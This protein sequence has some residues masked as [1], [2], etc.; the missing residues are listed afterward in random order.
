MPVES[1]D[2]GG[3][4]DGRVA[5]TA[6]CERKRRQ[7][8]T[9]NVNRTNS[10]RLGSRPGQQVQRPLLGNQDRVEKSA[11]GKE[12]RSGKDDGSTTSP[13]KSTQRIKLVKDILT[14]GTWSVQTL[15]ATGKLE[16]LRNEMKRFRHDIIGISEVRWTGK[17]SNK[18]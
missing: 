16:L 13:P 4:L 14:A 5:D 11:T 12:T 17:G 7:K 2:K 3:A 9:M 6:A 18:I 1:P 15:W 10:Y 8:P